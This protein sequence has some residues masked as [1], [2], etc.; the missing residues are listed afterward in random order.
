[1][2]AQL[3]VAAIGVLSAT[4]VLAK[5]PA[6]DSSVGLQ[7]SFAVPETQPVSRIH[8][9]DLS[10][11]FVDAT[12]RQRFFHGVNVVYKA[13]PYFPET[14]FW[15]IQYSFNEDDARFLEDLNMN[16]IRLGVMWP[17][18]EPER[19]TY[20]QTYFEVLK[21]I[22]EVCQ[23]HGIYVLL[24]M[25]QDNLSERYCG[26]GI[27][28]WAAN[29]T[30]AF[31]GFPLPLTREA[32]NHKGDHTPSRQQC[33][34]FNWPDYQGSFAAA[35]A[36]QNLYDNLNGYA[37]DMA[38]FWARVATEFKDYPNVLG[39]EI[40]NEPL[41][42]D[43]LSDPRLILE[44][45]YAATKVLEPF[46]DIIQKEIRKV[47]Q[48]GLIFFESVTTDD[49]YNG[50][51][52]TPGG[53]P[54]VSKSVLSYHYY[55]LAPNRHSLE[56]HIQQRIKNAKRLGNCGLMMT[57]FDIAIGQPDLLHQLKVADK[58]LQSWIGWEYKRY[59]PI[60]GYNDSLFIIDTG[61]VHKQNAQFL[62]RPF[63][64]AVAGR[65]SLMQYSD[66]TKTFDLAYNV[67][68]STLGQNTVIRVQ[69]ELH[70][71]DGFHI[72]LSGPATYINCGNQSNVVLIQ[73]SATAGDGDEIH[74]RVLPGNQTDC[75]NI[76]VAPPVQ[77]PVERN[78][79]VDL[80]GLFLFVL[81]V[82]LAMVYFA[83]K[84]ARRSYIFLA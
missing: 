84:N 30:G 7:W 41:G 37:D 8:G 29:S 25:H 38:A 70:Y 65:V 69:K 77:K 31:G 83:W 18:A 46:Y 14:R 20:N 68:P 47:D 15:D 34:E 45:G 79:P 11:V 81:V 5:S 52:K 74:V 1:M 21:D 62:S 16:V 33:D 58:Y 49:N 4:S 32:W 39:Y 6:Q 76:P 56:R 67:V 44:E 48:D 57:E 50:F 26:E 10:G 66:N 75:S 55:W 22:V 2:L 19:G 42:G 36:Y 17:G 13:F 51:T 24:D 60:T 78:R 80:I 3:A 12:D 9:I 27:P 72:E 53:E 61:E 59:I 64:E 54:Y 35:R 73:T 23:R 82:V 43:V 40:I 28:L 71:P 63:A